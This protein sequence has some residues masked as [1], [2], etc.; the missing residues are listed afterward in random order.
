MHYR[1]RWQK[2]GQPFDVDAAAGV[3]QRPGEGTISIEIDEL[4]SQH[5]GEYQCIANNQYGTA[6]S[7]KALLKR[8]SQHI[9][10]LLLVQGRGAYHLCSATSRL[11]HLRRVYYERK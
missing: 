8:A 4:Q 11:P 1:Y 9:S 3:T 5:D 6:V 2:N 10:L 7:V